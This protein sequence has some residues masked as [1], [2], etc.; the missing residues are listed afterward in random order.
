MQVGAPFEDKKGLLG[1]FKKTRIELIGTDPF[2]QRVCLDGKNVTKEI[3]LPEVTKNVFHVAQESLIRR[4]MVKKQRSMGKKNG[5]VMEGRDIGT[6]VFPDA[7]YKF[8]F[9]ANDEIRARRRYRE[10][11]AAGQKVSLTQVLREQKKRDATDYNRK[12]GPLKVA[13]DAIVMDTSSLTIDET[14]DKILAVIKLSRAS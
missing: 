8:Y 5:A 12:E 9:E 1:L 4:E 3:R 10:L 11:I 13:K 14:V 7:D 2:K 6:K